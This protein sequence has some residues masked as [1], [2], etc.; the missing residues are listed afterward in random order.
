M[1]NKQELKRKNEQRFIA[2]ENS[3]KTIDAFIIPAGSP[4][5]LEQYFNVKKYLLSGYG[6]D[7]A[8][9]YLDRYT[10]PE[11]T[12]WSTEANSNQ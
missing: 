5:I 8:K 1:K 4:D 12:D 3:F 11:T 6:K 2:L 7:I 9:D 10:F